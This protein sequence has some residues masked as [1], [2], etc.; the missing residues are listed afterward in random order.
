[1]VHRRALSHSRFQLLEEAAGAVVVV[2]VALLLRELPQLRLVVLC[3]Q[4][5]LA[6][7]AVARLPLRRLNS[8]EPGEIHQCSILNFHPTQKKIEN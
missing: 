7:D 8:K 5:G 3:P 6:A 4:V 2:V 1:M